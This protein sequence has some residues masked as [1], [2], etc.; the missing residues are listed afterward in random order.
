MSRAHVTQLAADVQP[1]LL[2]S[3]A[4]MVV[5][6]TLLF[7][8]EAIKCYYSFP[9]WAKM[10]SLFLVLVFT[11]TVRHR[12]ITTGLAAARPQVGRLTALTSLVLWF[13]VAF[14][15]RWIGFS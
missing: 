14:G 8:S 13:G 11:F 5:T 2:G 3:L 4:V 12:V 6:G 15:G 9:F 7:L 10:T 1:W